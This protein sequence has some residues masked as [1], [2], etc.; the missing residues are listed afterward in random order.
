MH[1]HV[2]MH[3]MC[4]FA[5]GESARDPRG[6]RARGAVLEAS[7]RSSQPCVFQTSTYEFGLH[8]RI[9]NVRERNNLSSIRSFSAV[10]KRTR[11]LVLFDFVCLC[12]F[13]SLFLLHIVVAAPGRVF[14]RGTSRSDL[15]TPGCWSK[16]PASPGERASTVCPSRRATWIPLPPTSSCFC[17][18]EVSVPQQRG[19][20]QNERGHLSL[21]KAFREW[22]RRTFLLVDFLASCGV[23]GL[24]GE[25]RSWSRAV[26]SSVQPSWTIAPR[27]PHST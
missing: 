21:P 13:V 19:D 4:V 5:L 11:T 1:K 14:T 18:F 12:N 17:S 25:P 3:N 24:P 20:E 2:H 6:L 7:P 9:C 23:P 10:V 27:A 26:C 8:P 15:A 22:Y 16:V